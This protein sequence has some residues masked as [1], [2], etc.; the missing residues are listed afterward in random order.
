VSFIFGGV[1]INIAPFFDVQNLTNLITGAVPIPIAQGVSNLPLWYLVCLAIVSFAEWFAGKYRVKVMAAAAIVGFLVGNLHGWYAGLAD[2]SIIVPLLDRVFGTD[3]DYLTQGFLYISIGYFV[4]RYQDLV[5]KIPKA[6]F[7]VTI[8][9]SYVLFLFEKQ[10]LTTNGFMVP[11]FTCLIIM[12]A[13]VCPK[14]FSHKLSFVARLGGRYTLS[15]YIFHPIVIFGLNAT[16][17]AWLI[18]ANLL[19]MTLFWLAAGVLSLLASV[20][21]ARAID[22]A[23]PKI[24]SFKKGLNEKFN[25]Y[26]A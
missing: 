5:V 20:W 16:I 14:L 18:P 1:Q 25:R 2:N 19:S 15:M 12:L 3:Q 13:V 26:L 24:Q 7:A 21:F 22:F 17:T 11:I 9:L 23:A 4:H 10:F 8:P 6:V